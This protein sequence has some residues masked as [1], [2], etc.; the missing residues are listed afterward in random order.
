M[1]LLV[2]GTVAVDTVTTPFG[3][4]EEC[5]GGSAVFFSLAASL[6]TKVRLVGVIGEDYPFEIIEIFGKKPIDTSGL[7]SR[8]G[9]KTFRWKGSYTGDMNEA[10]T[11]LTELN[12]LLEAPPAVP[13]TF[14]DSEFVF[15]ANTD[16]AI[17]NGFVDQLKS[18]KFVVA[19][20]MN[21]WLDNA[22]GELERL[23]G[24]IDML[25][26]NDAEARCLSG[27]SNLMLAAEK[28]FDYGPK[29][30]VIKKGEHGSILCSKDGDVFAMPAFPTRDVVDPTGAGD[31]FAGGMLG[32]IAGK[33]KADFAALRQAVVMGTACASF[34]VEGFSINSISKVTP[35]MI[36]ERVKKLKDVTQW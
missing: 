32:Y 10:V 27:H 12:V 23:L 4:S 3:V 19:D 36:Q 8:R 34:T 18:A 35:E 1:S 2:T 14:Q 13:Q 6:F 17:Q 29:Y 25:V 24:R 9:S 16:P 5:V 22:R 21:L 30:A 11:E 20:T 26:L 7:E 33:G 15:L 31:S 28:I